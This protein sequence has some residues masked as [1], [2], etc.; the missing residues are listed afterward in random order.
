MRSLAAQLV[1]LALAVPLSTVPSSHPHTRTSR[2]ISRSESSLPPS[3]TC[4]AVVRPIARC[5]RCAVRCRASTAVRSRSRVAQP[6]PCP[7]R[8]ASAGG[9]RP[10]ASSSRTRHG[11]SAVTGPRPGARYACVWRASRPGLHPPARGSLERHGRPRPGRAADGSRVHARLRPR[12]DRPPSRRPGR[13]LDAGR[14]DRRRRA[15]LLHSRIR[16]LVRRPGAA[17]CADRSVREGDAD[18]EDGRNLAAHRV[19]VPLRLIAAVHAHGLE[20]HVGDVDQAA[21]L[22]VAHQ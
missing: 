11:R 8:H 1:V 18:A 9:A 12:H 7:R 16:A 15:R 5:A 3:I 13:H 14:A 17:A 19:A 22:V 2:C 10:C 4:A 20:V 21:G 6:S